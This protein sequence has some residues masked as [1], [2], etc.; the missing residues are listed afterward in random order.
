MIEVTYKDLIEKLKGFEN[1]KIQMSTSNIEYP[2]GTMI[3]TVRFYDSTGEFITGLKETYD[4][5][6]FDTIETEILDI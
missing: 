4:A 6:T 3:Q 2:K 1:D 5:E